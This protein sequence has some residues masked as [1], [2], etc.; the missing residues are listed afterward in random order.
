[1]C[2]VC[3]GPKDKLKVRMPG[4][5]VAEPPWGMATAEYGVGTA[6]V[7]TGDPG[8]GEKGPH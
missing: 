5:G 7:Q 4:T 1:M 8:Y 6:L 2:L 3:G